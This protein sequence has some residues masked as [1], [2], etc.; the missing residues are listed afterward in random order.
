MRDRRRYARAKQTFELGIW[1]Y[2]MKLIK[3]VELTTRLGY[4]NEWGFMKQD[5][6]NLRKKLRVDGILAEDCFVP[7]ISPKN[8]LLHLHGFYRLVVP[9]QA[10]Q[11]HEILSELW[12]NIHGAPVVWVQDIYSAK[13]L[14]I[15]NVK[16]ALKNYIQPESMRM[17]KSKG[18]L[19]VGWKEVLKVLVRW[20]LEHGAKW[21]YDKDYLDDFQGEY[22]AFAWDILKEYV[23]RWCNDEIITLEFRDVTVEIRGDY[24]KETQRS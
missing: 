6:Q 15:Y 22:V 11:L 16:H 19:P 2:P 9:M 24:I 7:E 1:G 3:G 17:L 23:F 21:T 20:A 13:G 5:N 14:M 10:V 4:R 12:D 18:W 8:R